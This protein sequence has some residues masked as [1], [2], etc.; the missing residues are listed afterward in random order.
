MRVFR[1]IFCAWVAMMC[2]TP[3]VKADDPKPRGEQ[4]ATAWGKPVDGLQAGIRPTAKPQRVTAGTVA[5]F[6]VVVRNI[7]DRGSVR[8][9]Y[10]EGI[11]YSGQSK[12]GV[13]TISPGGSGGR[14]S[15]VSTALNPDEEVVIGRFFLGLPDSKVNAGYLQELSAG[16]YRVGS[17]TVLPPLDL[18]PAIHALPLGSRTPVLGTGYLDV[19]LR[20]AK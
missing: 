7:Q 19:E 17:E 14:P 8:V 13:V 15:M 18:A 16:K 6:E 20:P 1:L 11:W 5:E 9:G 10:Q 3:G 12:R 2:G 4:R